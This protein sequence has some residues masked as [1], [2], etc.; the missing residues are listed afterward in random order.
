MATQQPRFSPHRPPFTVFSS[1]DTTGT[2]EGEQRANLIGDPYAGVSHAFSKSGVTW[3]NQSAFAILLPEHSA[4][5]AATP[6][7]D[8]AMLR[9]TSAS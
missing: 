5:A 2:G 7:T 1:N 3:L 6:S 4:T 8:R 9:S